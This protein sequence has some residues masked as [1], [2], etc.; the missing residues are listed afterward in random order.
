MKG[1]NH[2]LDVLMEKTI[3]DL[4]KGGAEIIEIDNIFQK[5]ENKKSAEEY[6]IEIMAHEF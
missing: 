6:A 2:R 4:K 3:N 1:K 5:I